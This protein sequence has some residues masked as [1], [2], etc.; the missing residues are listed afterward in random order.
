MQ[1][2]TKSTETWTRASSP[3][4]IERLW[5]RLLSTAFEPG[6]GNFAG[7]AKFG[8]VTAEFAAVDSLWPTFWLKILI[9]IPNT[10]LEAPSP[11]LQAYGQPLATTPEYLLNGE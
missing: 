3:S 1:A 7:T 11:G 6:S 9:E 5:M 4:E 10:R 8:G 2:Q